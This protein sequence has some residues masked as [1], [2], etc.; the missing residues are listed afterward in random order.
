MS[1]HTKISNSSKGTFLFW[2]KTSL[3]LRNV[4]KQNTFTFSSFCLPFFLIE[5]RVTHNYKG[6]DLSDESRKFENAVFTFCLILETMSK[7]LQCTLHI[8]CSK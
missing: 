1:K 2:H 5:Y 7:L 8:Y 3:K 6:C 4:K